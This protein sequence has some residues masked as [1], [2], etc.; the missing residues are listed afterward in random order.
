[1]HVNK[2][3][4]SEVSWEHREEGPTQFEGWEVGG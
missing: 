3:I 2:Y 1:M 4:S